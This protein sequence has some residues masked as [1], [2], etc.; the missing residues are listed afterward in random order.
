MKR[1]LTKRMRL[2]V[3]ERLYNKDQS[4]VWCG[5]PMLLNPDGR[6]EEMATIE[7]ILPLRCGGTDTFDNFALAHFRC[8]K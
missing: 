6:H 7:H 1:V 4:C 2:F 3:R 5:E 8:N